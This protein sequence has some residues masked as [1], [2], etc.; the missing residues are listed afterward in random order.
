MNGTKDNTPVR[1]RT[2]ETM[3][4]FGFKR[5]WRN[6]VECGEWENEGEKGQ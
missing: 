3:W 4:N 2:K 6:V 5:T 1:C